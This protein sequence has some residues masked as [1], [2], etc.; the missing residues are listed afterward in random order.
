MLKKLNFISKIY[1]NVMVVVMG[2]VIACSNIALDNAGAITAFLG[3]ANQE[4][5]Q[6]SNSDIDTLYHPSD[7]ESIEQLKE[8]AKNITSKITEEGAVL[9][10]NSNN[11]LPLSNGAKINLYSSSSVN[12]IYSGGGSS[13]AKNSEFISLKEGLESSGFVVNADLWNWYSANK[14]YFGDHTTNT[15]SDAAKYTINDAKW[16][17]ISTASKNNEFHQYFRY[18]KNVSLSLYRKIMY[19]SCFTFGRYI[20][21]PIKI[22]ATKLIY[23]KIV[24]KRNWY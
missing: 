4:I 11:A 16:S 18:F 12:Y 6:N 23:K 22:F 5:I 19:R 13:F 2:V 20:F 15:S 7:Y 21:L 17:D 3:Q 14:Q 1:A 9:L 24:R 8:N 10:K